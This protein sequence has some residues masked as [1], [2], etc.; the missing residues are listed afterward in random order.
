MSF[1]LEINIGPVQDFISASR[2]TRDLWFASS[3]LSE[4]SKAAALSLHNDGGKLIFPAPEN[5]ATD[6]APVNNPN[7]TINAANVIL[8]EFH[9]GN[10]ATIA[11]NARKAVNERFMHYANG[12]KHRLAT[13]INSDMWDKQIRGIIEFYWACVNVGDDYAQARKQLSRLISGRKNIRDFMPSDFGAGVPKSSLDGMRESVLIHPMPPEKIRTLHR[14][15][16]LKDGECLDASGLI[17]RAGRMSDNPN[18]EIFPS[19]SRVAVDSWIRGKGSNFMRSNMAGLAHYCDELSDLGVLNRVR[20]EVYSVFPFE[21]SVLYPSRHKAMIAECR[22]DSESAEKAAKLCRDIA[23]VLSAGNM[24]GEPYVAVI[25]ADGDRMGATLS[26]MKTADQHRKFSREL[27]K[28]AVMARGIVRKNHGVC[29]YTGG[30]DVLAFLPLDTVLECSRELH[31]SFGALM[32]KFGN[33]PPSLSVGVSIAH[34]LEDIELLLQYGREAERIAKGDDRNG[35]AVTARAR[36]NQSVTVRE[37]WRESSTWDH[38]G[39]MPLDL[40]LKFWAGLFMA[41]AMPR[42]FPYE[43]RTNA[44]FYDNWINSQSLNEATKYDVMRIF[45]R[46]DVKMSDDTL[47]HVRDYISVKANDGES[48]RALSDELTISQWIAYG[49]EQA[50]CITE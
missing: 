18:D 6:L 4:L 47:S 11:D 48:I 22:N 1:L 31:D 34:A 8:A 36:G 3:M 24:P 30:D 16:R 5:P 20:D 42:K 27:S 26:A 29:I 32:G 9:D 38:A 14:A 23:G 45:A 40:R 25:C 17:R 43:L 35:L 15:V 2:R 12:V 46:K 49:M 28:F 7:A 44:G 10:P 13:W 21:G 33:E 19:I 37:Q 39:L 50:Q 41:G